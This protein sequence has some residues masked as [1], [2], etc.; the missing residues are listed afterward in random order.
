[1]KKKFLA[2]VLTL[3]MVLSLV[4]VTALATNGT[5]G[6]A[7]QENTSDN[8]TMKKTV[9]P[10]EDGT[11][12]VRL[13]SYATGEVKDTTTTKSSDIV[14][15]LDVSGSM[16]NPYATQET[17]S[18]YNGYNNRDLKRNSTTSL[19]LWY[20]LEDN[21]Y[22]P[23]SVDK[24]NHI[25]SSND[26]YT[27]SYTKDG[28]RVII[29]ESKGGYTRPQTQFY[30]K[31]NVTKMDALKEAVNAF[32]DDVAEKSPT[33][34][35]S[36]VK[37]AGK[38]SNVIGDDTYRDESYTY[39]YTQVVKDLTQVNLSGATALKNAVSA[40]NAAGA[41]SS[42]YALNK[43]KDVLNKAKQEKVII[44]FTDGQPNHFDGFDYKV[45]TD[46]VNT[47]KT[48]KQDNTTIYTV[49]VFENTTN[50]INQYMSSVSSNYPNA[51]AQ[52][53]KGGRGKDDTWTVTGGDSD[54]GTYYK[55]AD[56]AADLINAFKTISSQVSSTDLDDKAVVVD[57]VPS[58]FALTEGSV[59]VYTENCTAKNDD[60]FEWSQ[61][62]ES[63]SI[64]PKIENQS[65]SV[66]G[67]N[68]S[69]NWCGLEGDTARGKKLII[70]FTISRTN[71]GGTQ[72]TNAGA[73]I[74]AG[75][76]ENEEPIISLK[77]PTVPVTISL[78][79]NAELLKKLK[80]EETKP[81]DGT[82][83]AILS[84]VAKKVDALVNGTNNAYVIMEL[85]VTVDRTT[86]TYKIP[87]KATAGKWY[88]GSSTT[89]MTDKQIAAVTTL[90]DVKRENNEIKPYTYDFNLKLSDKT[91]G[92]AAEVSYGP[93]S[94][95]F[96]INP[97]LVTVKAKDKTIQAGDPKPEYDAT[98]SGTIGE[99]TVKYDISCA[100]DP[101]T[102][103][104]GT[105]PIVLTGAPTQGNYNVSY[106]NGTLTVTKAPV[107]TGTLK[108]TKEVQGENLTLDNLPDGFKITVTAGEGQEPIDL[109]LNGT[110]YTATKDEANTTAT[111]TIPDLPAGEYTVSETGEKLKNYTCEATYHAGTASDATVTVNNANTAQNQLATDAQAS[112][113]VTVTAGSERTMTVTNTYTREV[114]P[115][116]DNPEI[117]NVSKSKTA[118]PLDTSTWTSNVTLSLPSAE[119]EPVIDVVFILDDTYAGNGIFKDAATGL[120]NELSEKKNLDVNVGIVN[121]DAVARDWVAATTN[122]KHSGLVSLKNT[123]GLTAL[124]NAIATKLDKN[125]DGQTKK[126]GATNIEWPL[127]MAQNMLASGKGTE[128]Y[129]ILFSDMYGYVYRGDLI[130][131]GQTYENVPLSKRLYAGESKFYQGSL[132]MGTKYQSF[133]DVYAHRND[134][135]NQTRDGFFRDSSW[136]SYWSIYSGYM[137]IPTNPVT[138]DSVDPFGVS[139]GYSGFEKSTCLV[140]DRLLQMKRAG[141]NISIVNNDFAPGDIGEVGYVQSIKNNML[142]TL[143][144]EGISV[145]KTQENVTAEDMTNVFDTLKDQLIQVVSAGSTVTDKIGTN[146]DFVGLNTMSLKIGDDTIPGVIDEATNT[147]T[148]KHADKNDAHVVAYD[149]DANSFKWTI[150]EDVTKDARVQLTYTVKLKTPQ[151][152]AG[153]Y[154]VED[155]N[156]DEKVDGTDVAVDPNKA[157]YTNESAT[158]VP[159]DSNGTPGKE[160]T[161]PK[162]SVSYTI[163][164]SSGGHGGNGGGTV[165]IPDDV[166]TG[167]N[168]K[169][170]YAYVV[171]YP[172]GMVYPQKNITRAEVATIFF[173]LLEDETR[174]AN[175][176]KSNG[177]TD[178]KDGAWYTCAVSTLSKMGII[179][180]YEDGSFKPDASISR[181]EFAAI[182]ARFDPDGDKTPA[183]F[184]DVSSHWAKDEI[185][186]AANHGWIKGYEDG[187]FK[188]D[189]KITR[190]ETMTL[191]NRVLK[192][193]P[194]TKDDLHKDMKTW[195]D[196]QKESAWFYLAVQEATNSHYQKLKKDGTHEKWESMRETRDWAALEK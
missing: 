101:A 22:V 59:K 96:T 127:E 154:G 160:L 23:V 185:S 163:K 189:Q 106:E 128:K 95:N 140:Y 66:T 19:G 41:T 135:E 138:K 49:G 71:Y 190:A 109:T 156:G 24:E 139:G 54:F 107:T 73:Y 18:P 192:R 26:K 81:Y 25:G 58:N 62:T 36:I 142:N 186:I 151:T 21:T 85:T 99:E 180:G 172:D 67:F 121:F 39:N 5:E 75:K 28:K 136:D 91:E 92:G 34:Q 15:L 57:N 184:S 149:S 103:T 155:L 194:E 35:I 61:K 181:A 152:L 159:K 158:M 42:D 174:E 98:V 122:S 78:G 46:A 65:I 169:D 130:I 60:T 31:T 69:E 191:V 7:S 126:I 88:E 105:I 12:T 173:R 165:T 141:I 90:K 79:S 176:T 150:N 162:P 183:T 161:F 17:Y 119:Y 171:G 193:L 134:E 113:Q 48:L 110:N 38:E 137:P 112:Q 77:D 72:P 143:E 9:I 45:A 131:D 187:S 40:L 145:I 80:V 14:L 116:P 129:A 52:Y 37:F 84:E 167:L 27:Y 164:G 70:E 168:G 11:Y 68:F 97:A 111:W 8:L 74:K 124:Q 108:V 76:V 178:M 125:N 132:S 102:S 50:D 144:K 146:F 20:K 93:Y 118:T 104:E 94:A 32:I 157:L 2:L 82:G 47:A 55:T 56:S 177:Y 196:N 147:I 114:T 43:A 64:K 13:E 16:N 10:N 33:S 123:E 53:E 4:P 175:M 3:A 29:E 86:Y 51:T 63:T 100:Y 83:F 133:A 87:A 195:P 166:P 1:M 170:H 179:K 120:L 148:F 89:E 6:G 182:A 153:T 117:L 44:L 30:Y 115:K 188:P